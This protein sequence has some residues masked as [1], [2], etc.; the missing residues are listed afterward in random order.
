LQSALLRVSIGTFCGSKASKVSTVA[1]MQSRAL[2]SALPRSS[3]MIW[4]GMPVANEL[5]AS[6]CDTSS[7]RPQTLVA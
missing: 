7:L 3:S 2:Q 4:S 5:A 6:V 1:P